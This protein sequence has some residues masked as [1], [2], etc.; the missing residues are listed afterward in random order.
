MKYQTANMT[1]LMK[2]ARIQNPQNLAHS[3]SKLSEKKS[4]KRPVKK[5]V[6][7]SRHRQ[8]SKISKSR[9]S[10]KPS[11]REAISG[12]STIQESLRQKFR[13]PSS[14]SH[15]KILKS[16]KSTISPNSLFK[17]RKSE[18][19]VISNNYMSHSFLNTN[20]SRNY[21]QKSCSM[22]QTQKTPEA[23]HKQRKRA[24]LAK[25]IKQQNKTP[26]KEIDFSCL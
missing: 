8:Q 7:G 12:P 22:F 17:H 25:A 23:I 4:S 10:Q 19:G 11:Q 2:S 18:Y 24:L 21:D 5:A 20:T 3:Q 14:T 26:G 13:K 6:S 15:K 1:L 9:V 16:K